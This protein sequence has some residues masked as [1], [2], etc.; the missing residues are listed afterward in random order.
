MR[1]SSLPVHYTGALI[2]W[3]AANDGGSRAIGEH[4]KKQSLQGAR[5]VSYQIDAYTV[6]HEPHTTYELS[7]T[8][9]VRPGAAPSSMALPRNVRHMG[10]RV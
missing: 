4:V 8:R 9:P 1:A 10:K 3:P 5:R 7:S 6:Y 2:H